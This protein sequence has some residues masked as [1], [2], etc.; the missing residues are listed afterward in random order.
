MPSSRTSSDRSGS[1]GSHDYY[2]KP[3]ISTKADPNVAMNEAQPMANIGGSTFSLRA[4]QHLD[5][6]GRIIAEPDI[7]NPTRHRFERPLDTIRSFEAAIET[8]RRENMMR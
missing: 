4:I 7:S 5:R 2:K 6:E 1:V 8:H 3:S